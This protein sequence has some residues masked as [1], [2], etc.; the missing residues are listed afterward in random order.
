MI[1]AGNGIWPETVSLVLKRKFA[2]QK[3]NEQ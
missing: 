1:F 3:G 2:L